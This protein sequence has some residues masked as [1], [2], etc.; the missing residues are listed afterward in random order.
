MQSDNKF[1]D[2]ISSVVLVDEN[3]G[4]AL[5][6]L[7]HFVS[8]RSYLDV[9][10]HL[11]SIEND[12]D[13]M[14]S[15]MLRN[16]KDNKQIYVYRGLLINLYRVIC[17]IRITQSIK[18]GGA[19]SAAYSNAQKCNF[20]Q[21]D[22]RAHLEGFIQ[23]VAMLSLESDADSAQKQSSI[24]DAHHEYM[25]SLFDAI[26]VSPPWNKDM[27]TFM[28]QLVLSP[29]ID[30]VDA[31]LIVSAVMLSAMNFFDEKK[32]LMLINIYTKST[33]EQM[34]Q[35]ALIGW[36]FCLRDES[37]SMFY[38]LANAVYDIC[39]D[40]KARRDILETQMQIF[41]C[42]NA[43]RDNEEIQRDIMP[44]LIKNNNL[45][46]TDLGIREVE[47]DPMQDILNPGAAD[48]AMSE[49]EESFGKMMNMQKAGSDI[50]FGGFSQMKRFP[51]FRNLINWFCPFYIEHPGLQ[52]VNAKMRDSQ[53]MQML[54]E[55]GPF[56]DSD[57]YSFALALSSVI[58]NLPANIR[59]M[60]GN[61]QAME[62][63]VS[64]AEKNSPAYIRRMYLQDLYRFF[65]IYPF[66]SE[67]RNPFQYGETD[68]SSFFFINRM[69]IASMMKSEALELERF[70]FKH[71]IYHEVELLED[72]YST[73]DNVDDLMIKAMMAMHFG[74]FI[75]AQV[76]Y[77]HILQIDPD[78]MRAVKGMAHSSFYVG[79]YKEAIEFYKRLL[80][81]QP[82]NRSY[83]LNLCISQIKN[84]ET[85]EGM[86]GLY[87]LSFDYAD[88]QD[89]KRTLAWGLMATKK[90][91]AAEKIYDGL[92]KASQPVN[93]DY[94]NAGYCKWFIRKVPEAVQLF[95]T[96]LSLANKNESTAP[97]SIAEEMDNDMMLLANNGISNV[98]QKLMID[99]VNE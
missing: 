96:Y 14:K 19:M 71:K 58:E 66:R 42:M 36:L 87:K 50:Y 55:H 81:A 69:F 12:Y 83:A 45:K 3:V 38:E 43:E 64:D 80:E 54:M 7:K 30:A 57:K 34:R 18:N 15:F 74:H 89:V 98:E 8:E 95:K 25:C 61:G 49:L 23:D 72:K 37:T 41:Y 5:R 67:F 13:L 59:E 51:F 92:L 40:P 48:K 84:H 52:S 68:Y 85:E 39:K 79:D 32:V 16:F 22:I 28:E 97:V 65:R 63:V 6:M 62:P 26:V 75:N 70:L 24:Y 78:N 17:E 90:L 73:L 2:S 47:D 77:E 29:T 94:L 9:A 44:N 35:R 76:T 53:L 1:L 4:K 93:A 21:E 56:C 60:L 33:S 11:E 27:A 82:D 91:V 31:Q 86:N 99:I 46:M 20:Q 88:D 10:S